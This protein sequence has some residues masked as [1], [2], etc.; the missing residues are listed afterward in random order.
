[1][2]KSLQIVP[3]SKPP[4]QLVDYRSPSV[5]L[6]VTI[7]ANNLLKSAMSERSSAISSCCRFTISVT[8]LPPSVIRLNL[9]QS[10][11]RC[12]RITIGCS[13]LGIRVSLLKF[14]ILIHNYLISNRLQ[15]NELGVVDQAKALLNSLQ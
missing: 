12:K 6:S 14:V 4:N 1:M 8:T 15:T 10:L 3:R 2:Q 5:L 13:A 9:A 11:Q 7:S